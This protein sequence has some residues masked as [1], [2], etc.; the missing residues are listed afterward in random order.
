LKRKIILLVFSFV[1][2]GFVFAANRATAQT[3]AYRQTNLASDVNAPGFANQVNLSLRN[4]WGIAFLPGQS[5]FIANTNN[6]RVTAHDATGS[7]TAPGGFIV[8]NP[9]GNGPDTPTDIVADSNSFFGGRDLIQP[10]IMAT[11]NGDIFFW[12]VAANGNFLP[13]ATLVVDH[14][15]SGAVYTGLAI[16]TPDCC[17]P[18]LAVA[19]F[20]SGLVEAY[21]ASFAPLGPPGSFTDPNLPAGYATFGM[22]VIGNQ[23]FI[24]YAVQDAA[25]QNPIFG[26]GNGIVSVFDQAGNFVRRFVTGGPLNAPWGITQASA[27]FGPFS[28]DILIGN[29]GDGTINAFDPVTGNFAGQIKDGDGNLI[30]DSG[31]H[32]LTFRPDGFGDR[33]TLYFTAGFNNGQDGLFG[34]ITPG[35]VSTTRVSVPPTPTNT[36]AAIIVTVSAGPGNPG[37]P[38]GLVAVQDGGVPISDVSLTNGMSLFPAVLTGVGIHM[39]EAQYRGDATFL[40]SSSQTEVQVTGPATMLTLMAP[41]NAAPGSPVTLTAAINSAGG[42]PTGQIV[43]HD[44]NT[45]LGAAP[46]NAVGVA[47]LTINT[48]TAG[49]HSLTASYAG[50]GNF[51]GSTSTPVSTT[52]ASRDFSLGVAPP[53]ATVTAGQSALFNVAVT[54]AGGFAD[55]VTFSCPVFTGIT[56]N[57]SPTTVTPNSGVASTR[58]T[59]TTSATVLR[60][61]QTL[62]MTGSGLLL[63]SLGLIGTLVLLT[64]KT[65]G[66]HIEFLRVAARALSV[67]TLA[68]ALVSCGGYTTNGQTS[69]GTA[70]V[71]VTAQSG[72]IS[73]TTNVS[74]TVR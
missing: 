47:A 59:V 38:T 18:F 72:A 61:G 39:I 46:L 48:L 10:F 1:L 35:Q 17:A 42:T 50:D 68:L 32:A 41:A 5:F 36:P 54:S 67:I 45:G 25:K 30:V 12:G 31:L 8:P 34:R 14:A 52:I 4:S 43:F 13:E 69:R 60:Y 22:Q 21:T 71:M 62:G 56:C 24:A 65:R 26:A 20:R 19:N 53:T 55:P 23:L 7:S 49:A 11:E 70:S 57:F 51:G 64:R 73:H 16:L 9:A 40:P 29:V 6:G 66:T 28:K 27:N 74:V 3:I 44:G 58:L 37:T 2:V 63:A 33:N 15:Q